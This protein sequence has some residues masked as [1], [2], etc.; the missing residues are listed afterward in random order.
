LWLRTYTLAFI[1]TTL[2]SIA[3]STL[4][5]AAGVWPHYGLTAAD[6]P[7]LLP[8]AST[9]WPVFYGLRDGT[10]RTLVAIGSEGVITFPSLHA[11]LAVVLIAALWPLPVLRWIGLALNLLMLVATPIDGSHY[12]V[13]VFAGIALAVMCLYGAY[14]IAVHFTSKHAPAAVGKIPQFA[15][16]K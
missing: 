7:H 14:R 1:L 15:A 13:D 12:F 8:A 4:L 3:I 2:A 6:S 16:R 5:P 11:A 10:L 9:S